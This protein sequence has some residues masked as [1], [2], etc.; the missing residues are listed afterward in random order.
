MRRQ[1]KLN[2]NSWSV[3]GKKAGKVASRRLK[4]AAKLMREKGGQSDA[5]FYDEVM[6]ALLGYAGDKLSL[7][8]G[9]LTKDN[10]INKLAERGVEQQLVDAFIAVLSDCEFARYAPVDNPSMAKEK[11]YQQASD[12]ITRM[13]S[14]L[15]SHK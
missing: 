13:D 15:K 8:Q 14:L 2:P 10:V 1:Q 7:P 11:I 5:A 4:L 6:R 12:V 9:E 3:K